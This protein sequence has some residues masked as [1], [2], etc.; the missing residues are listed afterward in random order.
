[1][2]IEFIDKT[3]WVKDFSEAAHLLTFRMLKPASWDRI[4]FAMLAVDDDGSYLGYAVC[5]ERDSSTLFWQFGGLLPGSKSEGRAKEVMKCLLEC[6]RAKY[7]RLG[8]LV[9]NDNLPMMKVAMD[10]G[11]RIVGLRSFKGFI[12]LEHLLEWEPKDDK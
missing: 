4:D 10:A 12:L 9:E 11:F 8:F 7:T 5:S 2:K 6:A 1:M 3:T